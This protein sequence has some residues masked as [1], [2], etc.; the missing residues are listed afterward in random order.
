MVQ[1]PAVLVVVIVFVVYLSVNGL[2]LFIGK[3]VLRAL[4]PWGVLSRA[5][6]LFRA[7]QDRLSLP[8]VV[9]PQGVGCHHFIQPSAETILAAFPDC[10]WNFSAAAMF[11]TTM[12]ISPGSSP[13]FP[14][15]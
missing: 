2:F 13:W 4:I 12:N 7:P 11:S 6:E 15:L 3:V 8:P 14:P 9:I 5:L 1:V 10:S